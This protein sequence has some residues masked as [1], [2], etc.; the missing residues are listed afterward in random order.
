MK[1][2]LIPLVNGFEEIEA[3]TIIDILRRAGLHVVTAGSPGSI[4]KGAHDIQ[5]STDTKLDAVNT[6]EFDAFVLP[7]GP[8]YKNLAQ[9]EKVLKTIQEFDA[10]GKIN[11][12]ICASPS[13]LVKAGILRDKKAT[14]YPGMEKELQYPRGGKVV[15]D[16][17]VI[18]GQAPGSAIEFSLKIVEK[19][20]GLEKASR[21]R[22]ELVI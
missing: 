22:E 13:V 14:I 19:L 4:V 21:L 11:A 18:T 10:S 17:N 6:K 3:I 2:V 7:G 20:V 8:G 9:S 15:V 12:A 5:I 16:G 1:K